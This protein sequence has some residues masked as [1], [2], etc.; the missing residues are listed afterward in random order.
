MTF[1]TSQITLDLCTT[2]L[3]LIQGNA[4]CKINEVYIGPGP[5]AISTE[6]APT[7]SRGTDSGYLRE[8]GSFGDISPSDEAD[9]SAWSAI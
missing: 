6:S 8:L 7:Y 9:N 5:S 2:H 4:N 1:G 3:H